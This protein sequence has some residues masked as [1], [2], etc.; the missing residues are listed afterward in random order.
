MNPCPP[1]APCH[2][3]IE[4]V[5]QQLRDTAVQ[6]DMGQHALHQLSQ[7]YEKLSQQNIDLSQEYNVTAEHRR[8]GDAAYREL[9]RAFKQV[10][11]NL[12]G[13]VQDCQNM[14]T[15]LELQR[16]SVQQAD[17]RL[18][19]ILSTTRMLGQSLYFLTIDKSDLSEDQK[20]Q[21]KKLDYA[22]VKIERDLLRVERDELKIA[23]RK[24]W[25]RRA[26]RGFGPMQMKGGGAC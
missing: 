8:K 20:R 9:E 22:D 13:A 14:Q 7:N 10:Q 2:T 1:G 11:A 19:H 4:N 18:D 21:Q 16:V 15:R 24:E 17:A 3:K 6:R 12:S 23:L 5:T 26:S 25:E